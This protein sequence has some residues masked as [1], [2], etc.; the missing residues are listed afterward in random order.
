MFPAFVIALALLSSP[1]E[2][3]P[4]TH[5]FVDAL[6]QKNAGALVE[7]PIVTSVGNA[8]DILEIHDDIA[9]TSYHVTAVDRQKETAQLVVEVEGT[10]T[11][12]GL[13]RTVKFPP[14]WI[15]DVKRDGKGGWSIVSASLLER[16]LAMDSVA[17]TSDERAR[18]LR[19]HPE[20][21]V[22]RYLM[23]LAAE[24]SSKESCEPMQWA[25]HEAQVRGLYDAE[26]Y[27]LTLAADIGITTWNATLTSDAANYALQRAQQVQ[28]ASPLA[29][30]YFKYGISLWV[31]NRLPEAVDALRTAASFAGQV[32]DPRLPMRALY[33]AG[34]LESRM[35]NIRNALEIA[36][37]LDRLVEQ[38]PTDRAKM[39]AAFHSAA[40]HENLGNLQIS[41]RKNEEILAAAQ[42]LRDRRIEAMVLF[43]LADDSEARATGTADP[44]KSVRNVQAAIELAK[45]AADFLLP[46]MRYTL[47]QQQ[48]RAGDY[49]GASQTLEQIIEAVRVSNEENVLSSAL[50]E[51][52]RVRYLQGQYNEALADARK[53]RK[54]AQSEGITG[55]TLIGVP[56]LITMV[57][58]GRA[59]R[60]LGRRDEAVAVWREAVDIVEIELAQSGVDEVGGAIVLTEKLDPYRELLDVY[61][62]ENQPQEAL[63]IAERMRARTLRDSLRYGRVDLSAGLD[64]Q[65]RTRERELEN[66]LA[67]ANRALLFENDAAKSAES[68]RKR[69][70]ARLALREFRSEVYVTHP[71]LG[72]R[73]A[74]S[75]EQHETWMPSTSPDELVVEFAI[76][77]DAVWLFT[78]HGSTVAVQRVGITQEQLT[79]KINDYIAALENRDL[80][81]RDS[82]RVLYDLLLKPIAGELAKVANV[83]FVPDGALWRLPFHT[84]LDSNGRH[85]VERVAVSYSPSLALTHRPA[86]DHAPAHSL[87]AFANPIIASRTAS[88]T[89]SLFRDATLGALPETATEARAVAKLYS[90]SEVHIGSDAQESTFKKDAPEYRILH[91]AAH[92]IVD[93]GAPMFSSIVLNASS[94]DAHDDGLLEAHEIADLKLRADL[95]VLSACETAR[96][97]VT[98]GEGMVG[99]S[100]AFLAAG[101]PTT[102]V[103]QWKVGSASTA[104]LMV[105][106]HKQLRAGRSTAS[107]LRDAMLDL[108]RNPQYRHPFYWAPFVVIENVGGESEQQ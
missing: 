55:R 14:W 96:G 3:E 105:D 68:R 38:Y 23:Q 70:D 66:A 2:F 83:R 90:D 17:M 29:D 18:L 91:L 5:A 10:A 36:D 33:M 94:S 58:E 85:L 74:D 45:T 84:L 89:R 79:K 62:S 46:S 61:A 102:V 71:D 30:A 81:Y 21:D 50:D 108:R 57:D 12:L 35:G 8:V 93:D 1:P 107:A 67:E 97:K 77:R 16:K 41:R 9:I 75:L 63:I 73:R 24:G 95:A 65:K 87:L 76:N 27:A 98:A 13:H 104:D 88:A 4:V 80:L 7:G 47:A 31:A 15:V 42:R 40:L 103:S 26:I 82:S 43:N 25:A 6:Q 54:V 48:R 86:Q 11:T 22:E 69:D 92:S 44:K 53:A 101:V 37:E 106:F 28:W 51:R 100:W 56:L 32:D 72:R 78:V 60:A 64:E 49:E 99:L 59:L 20:I 19:D 52:S 39:D 34:H